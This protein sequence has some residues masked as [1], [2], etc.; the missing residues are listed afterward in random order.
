MAKQILDEIAMK[1]ALTRITYEIIENNKGVENLVLVGIKTRG[2]FLARRIAARLQE[3]EGVSVGID[4]L[5]ISLYRD[6]VQPEQQTTSDQVA[7]FPTDVTDKNV[8][9][10]DDV[11]F[12]GRTIRAALDGIMVQGRPRQIRLAVLVDRGH[13]QLPIRADFVGKNI[14]TSWA[15]KVAVYMNEV[16]GQDGVELV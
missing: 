6:D 14:P 2:I 13:R 7:Q 12:T 3:L 10:V 5:D 9:L 1:R 8:V 4:E 11:L 16:D 15:E